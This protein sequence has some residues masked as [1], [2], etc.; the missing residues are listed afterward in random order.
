MNRQTV[1]TLDDFQFRV[2]VSVNGH[3]DTNSGLNTEMEISGC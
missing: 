2:R 3:L 1:I